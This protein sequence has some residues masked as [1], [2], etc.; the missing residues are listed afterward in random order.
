[1]SA[2]LPD[3]VAIE[4]ASISKSFGA[5]RAL[6]DVSLLINSGEIHALVGE[7]GAGKST[8]GKIL[9]GVQRADSGVMRVFGSERSYGSPFHALADG[10]AGIAQEIALV[11]QRSVLDNVFLGSEPTR[12]GAINAREL[13]R[14]F[15]ELEG[16][17]GFGIAPEIRVASLSMADQQRVEI[18][19]ALARDVRILVMDEPTAAL[20]ITESEKLFAI[21]RQLRDQGTTVIYVSHFLQEVLDLSDRVTVLRDGRFIKTCDARSESPDSLIESMLGRSLS[22]ASS[23]AAPRVPTNRVVLS[24]QGIT[25]GSRCRD[26]S[27]EVHAGEI[28][29]FAGLVGSGRTEMA[30]VIFGADPGDGGSVT[31]DGKSLR[32]GS[33][34]RSISA[35]LV[36]LPESRKDDGLLL[37][38]PIIQNVSLPYLDQV[39][40]AG[41]VRRQRERS[42][43]TTLLTRVKAVLRNPR[44]PVRLLSGGN[45]QK[46]LLARWLFSTPKVMVLDEPTRGVDVGAKFAIYDLIRGLAAQ[47]LAVVVISS[48]HEEL[49]E[50]ADRILVMRN[51]SVVAELSDEDKTQDRILSAALQG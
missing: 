25:R 29:G 34:S 33:P 1:M 4:F 2:D 30:R 49:I 47:G 7:N 50:L 36:Y 15:D 8:L 51:G 11:P 20:S 39:S 40:T 38:A 23:A 41:V 46:V 19:R 31:I 35:G 27:F 24:V 12:A 32:L 3:D 44:A 22:R 43:V 16:R 28:L 18:M 9:T 37:N 10:V 48:E 13:R 42:R 14:T 26:I 21:I 5:T 6:S 45:Q 17:V